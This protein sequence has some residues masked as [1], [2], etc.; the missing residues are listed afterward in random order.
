MIETHAFGNFVP[1][2]SRYLI[3]GSFP[4][5]QA[6]KGRDAYDESYDWFYSVKRNQ[7]WPI[8]EKVYGVELKDKQSKQKL[9]SNLGIAIADIILKCERA[10]GSNLDVNLTKF[11]YN[12]DAITKILNENKIKKIFFTSRFVEKRFKKVFKEIIKNN[13]EIELI[14]LPSPSP[15]YVLINREQKI[16]EYKK[17][18][19]KK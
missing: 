15:R 10:R 11:V 4:V 13:P 14:T 3:L 12:I 9:F 17:L 1:E 6:V 2:N 7:F 8:F 19:P 18:L 16:T 5:K